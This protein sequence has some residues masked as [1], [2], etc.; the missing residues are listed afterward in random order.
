MAEKVSARLG[1]LLKIVKSSAHITEKHSETSTN[2]QFKEITLTKQKLDLE[3]TMSELGKP[4][5]KNQI[6]I[7]KTGNQSQNAALHVN[8]KPIARK[9]N[10]VQTK[11]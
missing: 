5:P 6:K 4:F 8:K 11:N 9:G 10:L 7:K 3:W 1:N 2:L